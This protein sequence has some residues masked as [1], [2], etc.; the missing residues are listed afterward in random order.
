MA[1]YKRGKWYWMHDFVNGVEYRM[2]LKTRNWQE[3]LRLHKEKLNEIAEGKLGVVERMS[4]LDFNKAADAYLEERLLHTAEKTGFTD[5]ERCRPLRSFFGDLTLRRLTVDKVVE[6]QIAR[7]KDGVSGRTI[8]MEVGLLRRIMKKHKQWVRLADDVRM[9]PEKPKP[10][11]VLTREEKAVLLQTAASRPDWLIAK[12]AAIL[13][14]NT[15]MRGCELKGLRRRDVDLFEKVLMIRRDSTKTDAGVRVIPLNRDAILVLSELL[16]RADMLGASEPDHF[17]FPACECG[18][19]DPTKPMKGWRSAWRS[20][21]K[22]AGL[23]GLRFHD[24]R[25]QA[26]T[27]LCEAGLSDMTIMGIAGHVSR[28]MLQ[29]YSHIRIQA[30]REAVAFLETPMPTSK[31]S[32]TAESA[33][34]N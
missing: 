20:L 34:P 29:H 31:P 11:R 5:R 22:A 1:V 17:V 13:A 6:Y 7:R 16:R 26:I 2:S 28:E 21:S 19:I 12:C 14:L 25:H 10:A 32:E 18:V 9:L 23:K 3:A 33:R 15:T 8:N 30:R 24:L 4:Q 27:E